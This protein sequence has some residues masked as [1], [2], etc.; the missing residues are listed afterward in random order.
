MIG[1]QEADTILNNLKDPSTE[2]VAQLFG[3]R[4][5]QTHHQVVL[6]QATVA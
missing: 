4:S 1:P 6:L 5:K 3:L 2:D